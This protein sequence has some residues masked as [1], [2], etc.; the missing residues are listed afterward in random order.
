MTEQSQ[1]SE[2]GLTEAASKISALLGGDT[3][4][5]GPQRKALAPAAVEQ[6]EASADEVEETTPEGE[7]AADQSASPDGE[8]TENVEDD[9]GDQKELSP[10]TLVTVKIDGK[11][12]EVPL[13]EALE[14]YQRQSDYSRKMQRLK[15]EATAFEADRQQVEVERAQYGQLLTAL[16]AQLTQLMPQEPNWEQLHR[17]DPLNFPI[18]EKQ[19]RDYKERLAATRAERERLAAMQAQQE[20]AMLRQQVEQG[21]QF[22]LEKMP[23]WKDQAKWEAARNQLR[24]YGQTVGYSP[25]ELAQAYDPRAILVLEKARRYDALMANRP[26]PQQATGPKPMKAGST[27]STPKQATEVQRMRQRLKGTGSVDDAAR[28]FGLLDRR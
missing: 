1:P 26:K 27:A 14:G 23:E 11:T 20:Q 5:P 22:L 6:T 18:V 15:E 28:L 16:E 24:D 7:E 10:D 25:E 4:E 21:R 9:G 2:I 8:A 17:E 12:V 19:W 13:K 3:P